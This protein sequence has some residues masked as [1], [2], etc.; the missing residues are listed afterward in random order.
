M[1]SDLTALLGGMSRHEFVLETGN[2]LISTGLQN[3]GRSLGVWS[4]EETEI[5]Q[6]VKMPT[7][8]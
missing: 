1:S 7:K 8:F 2:S 6:A 5:A 3:G 4:I